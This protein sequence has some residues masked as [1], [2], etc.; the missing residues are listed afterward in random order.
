MKLRKISLKRDT[1]VS[2]LEDIWEFL[3]IQNRK[4]QGN[5]AIKALT[6]YIRNIYPRGRKK[7]QRPGDMKVSQEIM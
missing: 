2:A 6:I 3:G 1:L 4:T 7:L 5:V